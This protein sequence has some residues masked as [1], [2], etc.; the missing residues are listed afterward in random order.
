MQTASRNICERMGHSQELSKFK[1]G[2]VIGGL[3]CNKSICEIS[4][5]LNIP[6]STVGGII[7]GS[8]WEQQQIS[9]KVVG[10]VKLQSVH[11][12]AH[13]AQKS[14]TVCRVKS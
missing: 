14:P 6:R 1:R 8:N 13:S 10:N 11:A 2:T 7:S 9:H 4:L 5:L 3:L 12:E